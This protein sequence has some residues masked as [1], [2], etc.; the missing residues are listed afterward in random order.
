MKK[1]RMLIGVLMSNEKFYMF[2]YTVIPILGLM[3]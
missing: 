2:E 3:Y 1:I